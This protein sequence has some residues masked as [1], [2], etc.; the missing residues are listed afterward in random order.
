MKTSNFNINDSTDFFNMAFDSFEHEVA[1]F[2][3]RVVKSAHS[4]C[5]VITEDDISVSFDYTDTDTVYVMIETS[6]AFLFATVVS[7]VVHF[8][9]THHPEV[10]LVIEQH[11]FDAQ[12]VITR[13]IYK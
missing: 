9:A 5:R 2:F 1:E 13:N 10:S 3:W 12:F 7:A 8:M 4:Q 11:G 6:R